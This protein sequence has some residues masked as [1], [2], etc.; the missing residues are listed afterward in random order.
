VL[1][2]FE[3]LCRANATADFFGVSFETLGFAARTLRPEMIP[4]VA[5]HM[6]PALSPL[7]WHGVGRGAYFAPTNFA[8]LGDAHGRVFLE[9]AGAPTEIARAEATAGAAWAFTLVNMRNPKIAE[10]LLQSRP[11]LARDKSFR[12]G[13]SAAAAF[14][15]QVVGGVRRSPGRTAWR[16]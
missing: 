8:P 16:Q 10:G 15:N 2:S 11:D 13:M 4:A 3:S 9:T 6:A 12:R 1:E 5:E 7:F 14:W